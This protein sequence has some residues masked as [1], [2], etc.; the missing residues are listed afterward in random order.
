MGDY[1]ATYQYHEREGTQWEDIQRKFGN[2]PP[3]PPKHVP[4][5]WEPKDEAEER[6]AERA[7]LVSASLADPGTSTREAGAD[8]TNAE[9]AR[10]DRH[11]AALEELED[12]EAFAD[13]AFL[14][15]YRQQ[16]LQELRSAAAAA[17]A[18]G[19][20][21]RVKQI[22]KS[23]YVQEVSEA[24]DV[25]VVLLLYQDHVEKC[26]PLIH[27]LEELAPRHERTKFLKCVA[28][29]C[30]PGYRDEHCPSLLVCYRGDVLHTLVGLQPYG[31]NNLSTRDVERVLLALQALGTG[32]K[33]VSS[34][35]TNDTVK[36]DDDD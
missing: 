27:A 29:D 22:T 6:S 24:G 17:A 30:I 3:L 16:R 33:P 1:H 10:A 32:V 19:G 23:Q 7:L 25:W 12:D 35:P 13:D 9:R 36:D 18:K 21:G 14:E 2:L 20:F 4:P 15:E 26:G 31:G 11:V 28:T 8:G 5:S 34:M